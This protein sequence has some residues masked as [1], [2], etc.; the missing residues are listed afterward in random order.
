MEQFLFSDGARLASFKGMK[1]YVITGA[2][3]SNSLAP[4]TLSSSLPP[5]I[6]FL[7]HPLKLISTSVSPTSALLVLSVTLCQLSA[8][9]SHPH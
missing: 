3:W 8:G 6:Y 1:H 9:P 4:L 5:S 7:L 2:E